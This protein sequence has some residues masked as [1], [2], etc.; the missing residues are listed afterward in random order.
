MRKN[1]KGFVLMGALIIGIFANIGKIEAS[2]IATDDSSHTAGTSNALLD[3]ATSSSPLQSE[4][5]FSF[6]WGEANPNATLP[7]AFTQRGELKTRII[8]PVISLPKN[9]TIQQVANHQG[10]VYDTLEEAC[11]STQY[12]A[13]GVS[14]V[15]YL[16]KDV[17]TVEGETAVTPD[18]PNPESIAPP[19]PITPTVPT[20]PETPDIVIPPTITEPPKPITPTAPP[21]DP[22]ITL[23]PV[24]IDPP[25]PVTPTAP[26]VNPVTPDITLPLV[27]V[28]P[29]K[30]L[31][32][33]A[34][35]TPHEKKVDGSTQEKNEP[36]KLKPTTVKK[37]NDRKEPNVGPTYSNRETFPAQSLTLVPQ[38]TAYW[39]DNTA[40]G[41]LRQQLPHVPEKVASRKHAI[42]VNAAGAGGVVTGIGTSAL[43]L[44]A[45]KKIGWLRHFFSQ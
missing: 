17:S 45:L 6:Q 15:I 4:I 37:V 35:P 16:V 25:K 23:P 42:A 34:P 40:E 18:V 21:I 33:I 27:T 31:T 7:E 30:P 2:S 32:P 10:I 13:K 22:D 3:P 26:P 29:P 14:F 28:D 9:I 24:P 41:E 39:V 11:R 44:S 19:N 12:T 20:N 5:Y 8:P 1:I 38:S 43:L 36:K